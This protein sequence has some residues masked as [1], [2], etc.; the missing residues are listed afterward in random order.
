M[1]TFLL[2]TSSDGL[3]TERDITYDRKAHKNKGIVSKAASNRLKA[4]KT[5]RS[6]SKAATN[7]SL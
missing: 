2:V 3:R 7:L 4:H 1:R 6:V 5:R